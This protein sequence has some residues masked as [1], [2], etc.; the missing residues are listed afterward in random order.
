MEAQGSILPRWDLKLQ[1]WLWRDETE[2]GRDEAVLAESMSW[3]KT[4]P[5]REQSILGMSLDNSFG[6]SAFF[7][8]TPHEYSHPRQGR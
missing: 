2:A 5:C 3:V 8:H 7:L 6:P 4:E 1:L